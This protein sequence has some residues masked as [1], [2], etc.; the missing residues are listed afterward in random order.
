MTPLILLFGIAFVV[1]VDIRILTPVL[2]SVSSSL[3]A[4][5]GVVGL[6]MTSYTFAYGAGQL[7]YG[8]LSDRMGRIA[9]VRMAGLGF[10]LCTVLSALAMTHW[11]FIAI[12][13]VAGAFAGAVIPLALVYIGD[14][15]EYGRRQIV[16]GRFSAVT[17]A[18]FAFSASIGGTVAHFVSWRV[19][20]VGYALLAL[21]PVGLM[22]RLDA[23]EPTATAEA[24]AAPVHF[25]DFLRSGRAQAVYLAVFLEGF[26]VWGSATYLAAFG[27][28]R[29]GLDQFSV[30]LLIALLG[31][32]TMSSGLCM[33]RV[34]RW[35]SENALAVSGG[36]LMGVAFTLLILPWSWL[37]LPA[38]TFLLGLGYAALHTT[39]QLRG[40]E[41]SSAARGKAFSLFA[42]SLFAG[43]ATGTAAFGRLV[44]AGWYE[45]AFAISAAGLVAVGIGTALAGRS[46]KR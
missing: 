7:F 26:F 30:G 35:L 14:T 40:T 34:R 10:S 39:L 38:S 27:A 36:A 46:P 43:I 13:F 3:R 21:L 4:T 8:P 42:F 33:A 12:R 23:G 37:V 15:V 9:V 19:M 28:H 45:L 41:I 17:S 20:L 11:Q 44:D 5:P 32:G 18:A 25:S 31:V 1:C 6:A 16:L 29:H 24:P 22:W 2:P